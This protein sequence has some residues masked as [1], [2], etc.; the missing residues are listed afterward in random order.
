[1]ALWREEQWPDSCPAGVPR[2]PHPDQA[3]HTLRLS[4]T[5]PAIHSCTQCTVD[6]NTCTRTKALGHYYTNTFPPA[7]HVSHTLRATHRWTLEISRPL[8][9]LKHKIKHPPSLHHWR[10][11]LG[12]N[13]ANHTHKCIYEYKSNRKYKFTV[14]VTATCFGLQSNFFNM[15]LN[16]DTVAVCFLM[17]MNSIHQVHIQVQDPNTFSDLFFSEM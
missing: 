10:T 13:T 8:N 6:T 2:P 14:T 17:S 15:L 4:Y 11:Q 5:W 16:F 7:G 3:S 9:S 1:M 12:T